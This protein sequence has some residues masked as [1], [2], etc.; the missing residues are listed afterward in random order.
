MKIMN[1][2]N[3][4]RCFVISLYDILKW[5]RD[6]DDCFVTAK[7]S[8]KDEFPNHICGIHVTTQFTMEKVF[9]KKLI[10]L[11]IYLIKRGNSSW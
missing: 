10:I 9:N 6:D 1:Y 7:T 4:L 8:E 2:S 11:A 5:K 3:F